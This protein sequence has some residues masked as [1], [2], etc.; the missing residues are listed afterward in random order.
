MMQVVLKPVS[1]QNLA[2]VELL[3]IIAVNAYPGVRQKLMRSR[4]PRPYIDFSKFARKNECKV[5]HQYWLRAD[6]INWLG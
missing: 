6:I 2:S 3:D 5:N 4:L 1:L